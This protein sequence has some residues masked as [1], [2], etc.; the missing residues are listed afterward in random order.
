VRGWLKGEEEPCTSAAPS[1]RF[2]ATA[3]CSSRSRRA[4]RAPGP[5]NLP[6]GAHGPDLTRPSMR[7]FR[8]GRPQKGELSII[9]KF[10]PPCANPQ[11]VHG[12]FSLEGTSQIYRQKLGQRGPS[13]PSVP[14][15]HRSGLVAVQQLATGGCV[16]LR[17][18]LFDH[19][20]TTTAEREDPQ[21]LLRM[22]Q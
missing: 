5:D 6:A 1:P 15:N 3:P 21:R 18:G 19:P 9:R 11:P 2:L 14:P 10:R 16:S 13:K 4:I 7:S 12:A 8:P 20:E 17:P 22:G